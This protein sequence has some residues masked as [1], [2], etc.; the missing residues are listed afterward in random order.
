MNWFDGVV[1]LFI[2]CIGYI[3]YRR[4]FIG[5][6]FDL[7]ALLVASLAACFMT[8][9]LSVALEIDVPFLLVLLWLVVF[10]AIGFGMLL[11]GQKLEVPVRDSLPLPIW[12]GFGAV[13]GFLEAMAAIFV[14]SFLFGQF[15]MYPIVADTFRN[16][17]IVT[18]V[19]RFNPTAE[20]ALVSV[21]G[22]RLEKPIRDSFQRSVFIAK[23]VESREE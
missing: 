21:S 2:L 17:A 22:K 14:I 20:G 4:G 13:M 11:I 9:K 18:S 1:V 12:R 10:G 3:G 8:E 19:Q 7:L 6:L 23:Q 15:A 16:S 5:G